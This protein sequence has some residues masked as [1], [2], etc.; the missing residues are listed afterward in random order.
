MRSCKDGRP[1]NVRTVVVDHSDLESTARTVAALR[2]TVIDVV[3][4][5]AG[6]MIPPKLMLSPQGFEIQFATNQL[7][8]Y[9]LVVVL[10]NP[11]DPKLF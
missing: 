8:H 1:D 4:C 2:G 5:N 3:I 6:V 10:I 9:A 11:L 7:N